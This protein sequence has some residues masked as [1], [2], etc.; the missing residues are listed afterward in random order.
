MTF[1]FLRSESNFWLMQT[2]ARKYV[3]DCFKKC[4]SFL[5]HVNIKMQININQGKYKI[6]IYLWLSS[7]SFNFK[8][9]RLLCSKRS[10][11]S[12]SK[13]ISCQ[14][15]PPK[16]TGKPCVPF[17]WLEVGSRIWIKAIRKSPSETYWFARNEKLHG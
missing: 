6:V 5:L 13:R 1:L 8:Y 7:I 9:F 11:W 3:F 12:T 16:V 14:E 17:C 4:L 10:H 2:I 15:K